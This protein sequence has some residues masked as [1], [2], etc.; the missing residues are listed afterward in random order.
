MQ[1]LP[2]YS[3]RISSFAIEE[4]FS[5]VMAIIRILTGEDVYADEVR[6]AYVEPDYSGYYRDVL[7]TSLATSSSTGVR[8]SGPSARCS[9]GAFS[10]IFR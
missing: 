6:L 2:L 5:G 4:L 1:P 10:P 3:N 8:P 9:V 7:V